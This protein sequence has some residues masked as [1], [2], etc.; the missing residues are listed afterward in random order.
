MEVLRGCTTVHDTMLYS[1]RD[2]EDIERYVE[3]NLAHTLAKAIMKDKRFSKIIVKRED[4]FAAHRPGETIYEAEVVV[5]T[6]EE[7]KEYKEL[8]EFQKQMQSFVKLK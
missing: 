1:A 6:R 2:K 8:K 5:L 3:E 7:A 4:Y